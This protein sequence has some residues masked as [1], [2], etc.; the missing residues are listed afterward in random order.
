MYSMGNAAYLVETLRCKVCHKSAGSA[1]EEEGERFSNTKSGID[2]NLIKASNVAKITV[3]RKAHVKA[4]R[5]TPFHFLP[6][7]EPDEC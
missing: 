1:Q 3:A 4:L 6:V 7:D 5:L 2:A